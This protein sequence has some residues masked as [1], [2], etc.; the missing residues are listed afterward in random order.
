LNGRCGTLAARFLPGRVSFRA[1]K[2]SRA[3]RFNSYRVSK[4]SRAIRFNSYRVSKLS[5]AN[6]FNSYRVSKLSRA[7]RRR[8][9]RK[10]N[11][12]PESV[13]PIPV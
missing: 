1:S 11:K 3:I 9:T 5:R 4:L 8:R 2:L 6:R 10:D 12:K 7:H 13:I